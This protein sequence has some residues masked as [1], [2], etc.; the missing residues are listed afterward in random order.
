MG[1]E[2]RRSEELPLHRPRMRRQGGSGIGDLRFRALLGE[3]AWGRLPEPTRARFGK[4]VDHCRSVVY[5]GEIVQCRMS[6]LGWAIAQLARLFGSPLPLGRDEN[7][8][9]VVSVTEDPA[10]NGQFWTRIY[11]R[12]RGFPQVI[13]SSKRFC[14]PTGLEEYVGGGLGVALRLEVEDGALHF[15]TDHYFL[16]C[17]GRR[18]ALPHWLQPGRLRVSHI[19]CGRGRFAFVLELAH[20][21]FGLMIGQTALF[22]ETAHGDQG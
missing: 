6:C 5:A 14:G 7:V 4:R 11:G 9:A 3:P 10:A 1:M 17:L 18:L 22:A 21:R 8:P 13:H 15:V 2:P 19:D 12:R 16:S 20:P